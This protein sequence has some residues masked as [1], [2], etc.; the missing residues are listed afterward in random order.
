V[1]FAIF[2]VHNKLKEKA[3]VIPPDV[4]YFAGEDIPDK[5]FDYPWEMKDIDEHDRLVAEAKSKKA[6]SYGH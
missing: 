2:V 1:K 6:S 4:L 5:W 3:G